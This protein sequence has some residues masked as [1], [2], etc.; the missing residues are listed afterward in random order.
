M[1]EERDS[2]EMLE[3][4]IMDTLDST[5]GYVSLFSVTDW[6]DRM[7][8]IE[9]RRSADERVRV[10]QERLDSLEIE[11][12]ALKAELKQVSGLMRSVYNNWEQAKHAIK[13]KSEQLDNQLQEP[14]DEAAQRKIES[15][16]RSLE[17][18]KKQNDS[19]RGKLEMVRKI[20]AYGASKYVLEEV[21]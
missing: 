13:R 17:L 16:K 14:P 8:D 7:V 9:N 19:Y 21:E 15:L 11:N 10:L 12:G 18:L 20:T 1:T 2:R 6:L 5:G 3:N 4:S